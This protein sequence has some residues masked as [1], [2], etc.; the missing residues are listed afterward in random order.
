[1]KRYYGKLWNDGEEEIEKEL[2]NEMKAENIGLKKWKSA[3][4]CKI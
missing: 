1:M 3:G 4:T 2:R